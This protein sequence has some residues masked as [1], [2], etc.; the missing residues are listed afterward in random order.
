MRLQE[1][2]KMSRVET[3]FFLRVEERNMDHT[4]IW[5]NVMWSQ[6]IYIM[7]QNKYK[8]INGSRQTGFR[9]KTFQ[10]EPQAFANHILQLK[11][12][13]FRTQNSKKVNVSNI[14]VF[15][16]DRCWVQI[17]IHGSGTIR[18]QNPI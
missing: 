7:L 1:S 8:N 6:N 3:N 13:N 10:R 12:G 18:I 4:R 11:S 5:A 16:L 14:S 2:G 15:N 9:Q 17:R